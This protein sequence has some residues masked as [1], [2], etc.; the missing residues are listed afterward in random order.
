MQ[1]FDMSHIVFILAIQILV[2]V[3]IITIM[4]Q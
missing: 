4:Q 1:P 3:L 2:V